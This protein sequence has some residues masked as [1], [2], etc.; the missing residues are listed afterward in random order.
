M[1]RS[2]I[3]DYMCSIYYFMLDPDGKTIKY[4]SKY[5]GCWPSVIPYSSL[6]YS[7][8][9]TDAIDVNLSFNYIIKEDMNP[10]T[11]K[12]FNKVSLNLSSILSENEST[13]LYS[14][15]KKSVYLMKSNLAQYSN[16]TGF[17]DPLVFYNDKSLTS[18]DSSTSLNNSFELSFS[19]NDSSNNYPN[20]VLGDN[21]YT[22]S[23]NFNTSDLD[24]NS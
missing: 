5:T 1:V 15:I 17:R 13:E 16:T 12:D 20:A 2:G 14:P 21:W 8:G 3:L 6:A 9:N 23:S 22:S 11:L 18:T 19:Y 24:K 7:K 4:W 10:Q